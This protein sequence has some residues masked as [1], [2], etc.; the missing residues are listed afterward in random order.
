VE[1]HLK[2]SRSGDYSCDCDQNRERGSSHQRSWSRDVERYQHRSGWEHKD[3]E[4][5][6]IGRRGRG[7][8]EKGIGIESQIVIE[9]ETGENVSVRVRGTGREHGH[10]ETR[11]DQKGIRV[12]MMKERG[13]VTGILEK[14]KGIGSCGNGTKRAGMFYFYIHILLSSF[15]T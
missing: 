13:V 4:R 15:C 3:K 11:V 2:H 6:R 14:E 8:R 5:D 7:R 10:V 12:T 9:T 1:C